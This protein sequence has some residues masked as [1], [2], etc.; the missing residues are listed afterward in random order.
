MLQYSSNSKNRRTGACFAALL[1]LLLFIFACP[2]EASADVFYD[3]ESYSISI[4][5]HKDAT[6]SVTEEIRIDAFGSGHGI[7]RYIPMS[8]TAYMEKDGELLKVD[9]RM[10]IENVFVEGYEYEVD[11][12]NGNLVIR[13]GSADTLISGPQVYRITYDCILYEDLLDT[14]DFFYYNV[15]PQG[16]ETAIPYAQ[17]EVHMPEAFDAEKVFVYTGSYGAADEDRSAREISG[18]TVSVVSENLDAGEGITVQIELPDGYFVGAANTK[19]AI[20]L[21]YAVCAAAAV[22]AAVLWYVFGRDPDVVQ[23]V[24]FY[25]PD[26]ITP[27]EAGYLLD[28]SA[29]KE[30]LISMILYFADHGYL[31]IEEK[32]QKKGGLAGALGKEESTFILRKEKELPEKEKTFAA[33]LFDGI[34]ESG[35]QV[36]LEKLSGEFYPHYD[37]AREELAEEYQQEKE[38]RVYTMSS[39][40]A[41]GIGFLLIAAPLIAA[42]GLSGASMYDFNAGWFAIPVGIVAV[43]GYLLA[44][45]AYD[46]KYVYSKA[47]YRTMGFVGYLIAAAATLTA[48]GGAA[49]LYGCSSGALAGVLASVMAAMFTRVMLKR[50]K[51]SASML[52]R[53]L[54]FKEFIRVAE[55]DRI[56]KLAASDPAYFYHILPYAYVFGLSDVWAKNFEGIATE[57]PAWYHG[58]YGVG[59]PVFNTWIFMD[60]F[61]SCADAISENLTIPP[62]DESGEGF[63]SGGG[64]SGGSGGGFSGG[65]FG[66]GGGGGW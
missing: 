63:F 3:T 55:Q 57:P 18:N 30:D 42:L 7:Y 33:A 4:D 23:T 51:N 54:G 25:P 48:A 64:G 20:P 40:L 65:G 13:I 41:R 50:T 29:D 5:V 17:A 14:M 32:K 66:G 58:G 35:S 44:F 16:W 39:V 6:L 53:L 28:G 10:K 1:V 61:H 9:R 12:E 47:K 59:D 34:F 52:G 21:L 62:A 24:E 15:I 2:Q 26:G 56:E 22:I 11:T 31:S 43:C 46:K 37:A 49:F 27:A 19:W 38:S 45:T 36:D 60:S 8:G